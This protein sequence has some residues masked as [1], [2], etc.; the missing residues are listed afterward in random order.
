M[1]QVTRITVV[2]ALLSCLLASARAE[3]I[4][5]V[6]LHDDE[7]LAAP[8]TVSTADVSIG[9]LLGNWSR[10]T[11]VPIS[12]DPRDG[13][14]SYRLLAECDKVPAA[15]MME[16]LYRLFSRRGGEWAWNRTGKPG[17]YEYELSEPF[18]AKNRT[19]SFRQLQLGLLDRFVTVMRSMSAMSPDERRRRRVDLER[20]LLMEKTDGADFFFTDDWFWIQ[21]AFFFGATTQDQQRAILNGG[22]V[23]VNLKS[24]SPTVHDAFRKDLARYTA[25][26]VESTGRPE[27]ESV[28]FWSR[29]ADLNMGT[30]G[31]TIFATGVVPQGE[32]SYIGTG[33][34]SA[35][36]RA[37]LESLWFLPGDKHDDP[38]S[39]RLVPA[40]SGSERPASASQPAGGPD[41]PPIRRGRGPTV[42]EA[43]RAVAQATHTPVL[44][45]I[46]ARSDRGAQN[47]AGVAIS[48]FLAHIHGPTGLTFF[49]WNSGILMICDPR[50]FAVQDP[51]VPEFLI[52][53]LGRDSH[54]QVAL[55]E[56]ID[57]TR[58]I[59]GEQAEWLC[60]HYHIGSYKSLQP[61]IELALAYP[62][63]LTPS[64]T[65][66]D[67]ATARRVLGN[68]L[69]IPDPRAAERNALL[70]RLRIDATSVG[71]ARRPWL[72]LEYFNPGRKTWQPTFGAE[73][74]LGFK[75]Q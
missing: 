71:S 15:R 56:F 27:P 74:D 21:A 50:W 70:F 65:A 3:R 38:A 51:V 68:R 13:A 40:Q 9:Q 1:S 63:V 73:I 59:S 31:P 41:Q 62:G 5:L 55:S 10:Q 24:L 75:D 52:A 43:I 4:P 61:L 7:R 57:L 35:G 33:H 36:V 25:P 46:D 14:S 67:S 44:G 58:H 64:G 49:K 11:G 17:H 37:A 18:A 23:T 34:L 12:I 53:K 45:I 30:F 32:T 28:T 66:I 29:P 6:S 54:G 19:E 8:V 16:A 47:P 26:E 42:K 20:A 72:R 48:A 22:S 39:V 60:D 69:L 2:G